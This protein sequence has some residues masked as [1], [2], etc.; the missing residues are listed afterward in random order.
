MDHDDHGP[1]TEEEK[2]ILGIEKRAVA[3]VLRGDV[4]EAR[5]LRADA[6]LKRIGLPQSRGL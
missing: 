2:E 5:K 1:L 6:A 3:A 4:M